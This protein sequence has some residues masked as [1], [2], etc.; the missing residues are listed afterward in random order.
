MLR[1]LAESGLNSDKKWAGAAEA[2]ASLFVRPHQGFPFS[3][4]C[5]LS[6]TLIPCNRGVGM[7]MPIHWQVLKA[8]SPRT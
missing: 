2:P 4:G 8:P 7:W 6:L 1:P 5:Q 3:G